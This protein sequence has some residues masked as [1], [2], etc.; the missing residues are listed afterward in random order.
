MPAPD[1]RS[2]AGGSAPAARSGSSRYALVLLSAVMRLNIID[3]QI[4]SI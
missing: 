4:L 1:T 2:L 3:R